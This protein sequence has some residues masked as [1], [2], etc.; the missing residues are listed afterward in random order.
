MSFWRSDYEFVIWI[1]LI[2]VFVHFH[3]QVARPGCPS[4]SVCQRQKRHG[5]QPPALHYVLEPRSKRES[6]SPE[7]VVRTPL[8]SSL[9]D[10]AVT[11]SEEDFLFVHF[12]LIIPDARKIEPFNPNF[13]SLK[14]KFLK[15][16]M[17]TLVET[18][19]FQWQKYFLFECHELI[20]PF[21][22]SFSVSTPFSLAP[23][24]IFSCPSP[25]SCS[26]SASTP[27][28][29]SFLFGSDCFLYCFHPEGDRFRKT[30]PKRSLM[31]S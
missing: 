23:F 7:P 28:F 8:S 5:G 16:K 9:I 30:C 4:W 6:L 11:I 15:W 24:K 27:P 25:T 29:V 18:R 2:Q 14:Q 10:T 17:L 22:L 1:Q 12:A 19:F 20:S 21:S 13:T 31:V 3:N 26:V